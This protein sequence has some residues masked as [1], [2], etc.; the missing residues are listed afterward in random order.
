MSRRS[1]NSLARHSA[2]IAWTAPQV[3]AH[4]L[5]RMALAGPVPSARDRR[6]FSRMSAEKVTAFYESWNAMFAQGLRIQQE[7]WSASLRDMWFPWQARTFSPT[8][9][10]LELQSATSRI[11]EKGML[12]VRNRTVANARRLGRTHRRR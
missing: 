8:R 1:S 2:A 3:V 6:E 11:L 9:Q 12:P 4:R 5:A 10:M 7:M